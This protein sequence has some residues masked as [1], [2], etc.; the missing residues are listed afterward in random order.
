VIAAITA[1]NRAAHK[2]KNKHGNN[3]PILTNSDLGQMPELRENQTRTR[4]AIPRNKRSNQK[5][6]KALPRLASSTGINQEWKNGR[7]E[8]QHTGTIRAVADWA[9][10]LY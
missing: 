6:P 3:R 1:L 5:K 7:K 8:H 9:L 2:L 10:T 4:Q